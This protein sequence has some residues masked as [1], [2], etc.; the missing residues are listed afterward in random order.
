MIEIWLIQTMQYSKSWCIVIYVR[1]FTG[2]TEPRFDSTED[3]VLIC[4][5]RKWQF[6]LGLILLNPCTVAGNYM[7]L[8]ILN[9][10][11]NTMV[12]SCT[13]FR[14][15]YWLCCHSVEVIADIHYYGPIQT[16]F[17][18]ASYLTIHVHILQVLIITITRTCRI[19]SAECWHKTPNADC[20]HL[21]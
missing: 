1:T 19:L 5:T 8:I 2:S 10:E 18:A 9:V 20:D 4:F 7:W 6:S 3:F 11:P 21:L 14:L 13:V 12:Y 15:L 16:M 17:Q